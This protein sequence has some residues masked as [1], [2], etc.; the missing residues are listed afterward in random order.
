MAY[1]GDLL[2]SPLLFSLV[3]IV[4]ALMCAHKILRALLLVSPTILTIAQGTR[5]PSH[6]VGKYCWCIKTPAAEASENFG[7]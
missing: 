7:T 2:C 4:Y 6:R 5:A 3:L 1:H